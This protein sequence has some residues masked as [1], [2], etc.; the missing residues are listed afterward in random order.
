MAQN[1]EQFG[2]EFAETGM[3]SATAAADGAQAI[4]AHAS[5]Y[6]Q[7]SVEMGVAALE[8][9]AA[10]GSVEKALEI[11]ADYVRRSYADMVAEATTVSGL[12]ADMLKEACK[13]FESIVA[14]AG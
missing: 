10:A 6:A 13:P 14:K 11:Q 4:A 5:D 1:F 2:R 7:K 3:K 12:Y 9:L 8:K